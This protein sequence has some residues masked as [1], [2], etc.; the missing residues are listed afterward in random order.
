MDESLVSSEKIT[1]NLK[2]EKFSSKFSLSKMF[3]FEMLYFSSGVP[4]N[5]SLNTFSSS[6]E[7]QKSQGV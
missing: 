4:F 3:Y 5:L 6:L 1:F 7:N 2:G